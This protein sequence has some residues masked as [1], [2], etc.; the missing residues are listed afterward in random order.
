MAAVVVIVI[1]LI[2]VLVTNLQATCNLMQELDLD[3]TRL[4]NPEYV[5]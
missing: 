5:H 3:P 2:I 4:G 1:E